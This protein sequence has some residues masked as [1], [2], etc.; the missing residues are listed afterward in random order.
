[1]LAED[2]V[3]MVVVTI[4]KANDHTRV[5]AEDAVDMGD[6]V[7]QINVCGLTTKEIHPKELIG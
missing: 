4:T 3:V 2:V 5:D 7:V 1:M 6:V